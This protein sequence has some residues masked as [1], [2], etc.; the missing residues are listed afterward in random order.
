MQ[1]PLRKFKEFEVDSDWETI[2]KTTGIPVQ[3]LISVASKDE[4]KIGGISLS[5]AEKLRRT[6]GVNL[7]SYYNSN[8]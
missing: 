3:T 4:Q 1:N 5:T 7:A 6:I 8:Q 2:S